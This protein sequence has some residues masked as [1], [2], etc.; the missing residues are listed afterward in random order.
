MRYRLVFAWSARIN[1]WHAADRNS[2]LSVRDWT[3]AKCAVSITLIGGR[4]IAVEPPLGQ[5]PGPLNL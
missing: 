1:N 3:S 4:Y 5:R 2:G